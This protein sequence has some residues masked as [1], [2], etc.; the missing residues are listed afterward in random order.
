MVWA[1]DIAFFQRNVIRY[2][3][4]PGPKIPRCVEKLRGEI[5]KKRPRNM[6]V[7]TRELLNV[8]GVL[9]PPVS[10]DEP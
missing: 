6:A 1:A 9:H 4:F 8:I 7:V 5:K 10:S 3:E 2:C